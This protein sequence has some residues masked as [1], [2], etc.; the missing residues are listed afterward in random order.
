M[1]EIVIMSFSD[2]WLWP[3]ADLLDNGSDVC[4]SR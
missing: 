2:V 1:T 4:W 3:D